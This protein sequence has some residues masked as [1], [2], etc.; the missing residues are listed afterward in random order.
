MP[1]VK[2]P[3]GPSQNRLCARKSTAR[4]H[5]TKS[6][7]R[8]NLA[9][10]LSAQSNG[11][12]T[13]ADVPRGARAGLLPNSGPNK[14]LSAKAARKLERKVGYALQRRMEQEGEVVMKDAPEE[15][16]TKTKT[17]TKKQETNESAA[18]GGDATVEMD[19]I[20]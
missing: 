15:T 8:K 19:G 14:A 2:N 3:N 9:A 1:S 13:K 16:E 5:T 11:R 7:A 17:K 4:K 10:S 6:L 18:D 12:V 20:S